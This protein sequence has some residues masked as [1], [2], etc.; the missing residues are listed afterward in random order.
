MN[1]ARPRAVGGPVGPWVQLAGEMMFLPWTTFAYTMGAFL[2]LMQSAATVGNSGAAA[3]DVGTGRERDRRREGGRSDQ[4]LGGDELKYV[5]YSILFTK[6][7]HEVVLQEQRE[8]LV[9]YATDGGSFA[10]LRIA[11][12]FGRMAAKEVLR[13]PLW[14]ELG[15]PEGASSQD[16]TCWELPLEDRR[17]VRLIYRVERRI[18][19]SETEYEKRKTRALQSIAN[20]LNEGVKVV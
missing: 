12:F 7:D 11:E 9:N 15:Y 4:D 8:Q 20:T 5:S 13:P 6:R 3:H 18:P 19:R 1:Q 17:Y 10:A 16:P 2:F 14:V